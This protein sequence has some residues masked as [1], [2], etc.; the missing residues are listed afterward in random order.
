VRV[1]TPRLR[2]QDV[3]MDTIDTRC[4][5]LRIIRP[6]AER[7]REQ[8][9]GRCALPFGRSIPQA[10]AAVPR[11]FTARRGFAER[12]ARVSCAIFNYVPLCAAP[13]PPH[14]ASVFVD[15]VLGRFRRPIDRD[16]SSTWTLS[17]DGCRSLADY[18]ETVPY[19]RL[20]LTQFHEYRRSYCCCYCI[21]GQ[22]HPPCRD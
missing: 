1:G 22:E 7:R 10:A 19:E 5:Q 6:A 12:V 17:V 16:D 21:T 18:V 3:A 2:R 11:V 20:A 4:T 9:P 14:N 13:R 15:R 8:L